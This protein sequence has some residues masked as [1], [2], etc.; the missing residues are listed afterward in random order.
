MM[1]DKKINAM[2]EGISEGVS[3]ALAQTMKPVF[4]NMAREI[5]GLMNELKNSQ[6]ESMK[7]MAEAFLNEMRNVSAQFYQ[8]VAAE[9]LNVAR[10][11]A[12]TVNKLGSMLKQLEE[13]K[14]AIESMYADSRK[15]IEDMA[16]IHSEQ[17]DQINMVVRVSQDVAKLSNDATLRIDKENELYSKLET[18]HSKWMEDCKNCSEVLTGSAESVIANLSKCADTLNGVSKEVEES[19]KNTCNNLQNSIADY[20]QK[21]D[22]D[23]DN[24]FK[25]FDENMASIAGTLGEAASDITEAAQRIPKAIKGSLDELQHSMK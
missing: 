11:Q 6:K 2:S 20:H 25:L 8:N 18:N 24:T 3:T 10:M 15:M 12:D 14:K 16:K 4:D 17:A 19:L 23:I 5:N 21:V 22:T 1:N 7:E 13:D 9:S